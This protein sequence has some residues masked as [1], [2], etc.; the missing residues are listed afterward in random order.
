MR[1]LS[2]AAILAVPLL[3]TTSTG[4]ADANPNSCSYGFGC[5]GRCLN[6]FGGMHQHGPLFNYGPYYGY[7]PF[8]PYGP[9]DAYLRYDPFFYGDPYANSWGDGNGPNY[10]GRNPHLPSIHFPYLGRLKG[11]L[12]GGHG[13]GLFHHDG[14]KQC[15]FF[16]ASWLHGGWF[17]GHNWVHG[18]L[19]HKHKG[20]CTSCG[21]IAQVTTPAPT[22]DAI[23]RLSGVGISAQS[24]VFYQ[25][26]PTLNPALE[27][28]PTTGTQK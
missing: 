14:C 2:I 28:V 21:G 19:F 12:H 5:G 15:G 11:V 27:V 7:Y 25:A 20:D 23:T 1:R 3:L 10:Y 24:A 26:T 18:G 22:G 9:W 13:G 17:R 8:Y 6:L 4:T 16:H